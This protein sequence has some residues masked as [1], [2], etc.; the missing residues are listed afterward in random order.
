MK[1][2]LFG[3]LTVTELAKNPLPVMGPKYI[4][5]CLQDLNTGPYPEPVESSTILTR[6]FLRRVYTIL[7]SPIYPT[8]HEP[9]SHSEKG[10]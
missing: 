2:S 9:I 10:N 8:E 1:Q 7:C 3:K 4:L 6:R 5:P